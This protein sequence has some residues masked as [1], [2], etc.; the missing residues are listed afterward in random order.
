M[1][2]L[3]FIL[4]QSSALY[5]CGVIWIIQLIHYP[6]FA[7]LSSNHFQQFHLQHTNMMSL[8]VGPVMVLEL[9]IS[10][11]I[12]T[13]EKDILTVLNLVVVIGLWLLTFLVSVPLHN[14]LSQ[15]QDS[16][17]IQKLILTNWPRTVLWTIRPVISTVILLRAFKA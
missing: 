9:F 11:W 14:K 3:V 16:E 5:M 6:S 13:S 8:L 10:I 12:L 1:K 4:N 7:Q 17:T 2:N 15:G